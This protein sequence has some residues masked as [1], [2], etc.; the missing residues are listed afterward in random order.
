MIQAV[1]RLPPFRVC[2]IF[3]YYFRGTPHSLF[4]DR[5]HGKIADRARVW[6]F[7]L[8]SALTTSNVKPQTSDILAVVPLNRFSSENFRE[9]SAVSHYPF[10]GAT[11]GCVAG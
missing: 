5:R 1:G 2:G 4:R 10:L 6:S 9:I 3:H 11:V 7:S 8:A